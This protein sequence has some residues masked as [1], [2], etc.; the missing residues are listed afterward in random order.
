MDRLIER[1]RDRWRESWA[2]AGARYA[3]NQAASRKQEYKRNVTMY[4]S[5]LDPR[6]SCLLLPPSL[7]NFC[8]CSRNEERE[9]TKLVDILAFRIYV[10]SITFLIYL[11]YILY[12]YIFWRKNNSILSNLLFIINKKCV[13]RSRVRERYIFYRKKPRGS[14]LS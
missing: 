13:C 1:G 11:I 2:I 7:Q 6:A 5:S 3:V 4:D 12:I 9:C 10:C 8:H 14:E